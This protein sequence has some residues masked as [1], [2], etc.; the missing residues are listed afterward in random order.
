MQQ[1]SANQKNT[2]EEAGRDARAAAATIINY[3]NF[4]FLIFLGIERGMA[5][6]HTLI[7]PKNIMRYEKITHIFI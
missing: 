2:K 1:H 3:R 5:G 7:Y 6:G 4:V